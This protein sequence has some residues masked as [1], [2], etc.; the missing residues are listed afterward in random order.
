MGRGWGTQNSDPDSWDPPLK[1][2]WVRS[3]VGPLPGWTHRLSAW[4]LHPPIRSLKHKL[5]RRRREKRPSGSPG[6]TGDTWGL[7]VPFHLNWGIK[8]WRSL[9]SS[10]RSDLPLVAKESWVQVP[11]GT[12]GTDQCEDGMCPSTLWEAATPGAGDRDKLSFEACL[13]GT[14]SAG[15]LR[16][17]KSTGY[18]RNFPHRRGSSSA[19]H[20]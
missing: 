6:V 2:H 3:F 12:E 15:T 9:F 17:L 5:G 8:N 11:K 20:S 18:R 1:N 16:R 7:S 19:W 4:F 13:Q 10:P 14:H